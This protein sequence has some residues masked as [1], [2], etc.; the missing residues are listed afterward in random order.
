MHTSYSKY[1]TAA[2]VQPSHSPPDK[3]G[4]IGEPMSNYDPDTLKYIERSESEEESECESEDEEDDYESERLG[5]DDTGGN[6]ID[7]DDET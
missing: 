5:R 7:I 4:I 1:S 6:V 2:H 3:L